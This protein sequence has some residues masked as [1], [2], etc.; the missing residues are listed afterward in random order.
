LTAA[1]R[2]SPWRQALGDT[3]LLQESTLES[4]YRLDRPVGQGGMAFVYA[5]TD[6]QLGGPV[7]IKVL[8]PR[9]AS[10]PAAV[11]RFLREAR[12][13][14]SARHEHVVEVRDFGTRADGSA[15]V[16][17]EL[18][19][20]ETFAA[21]LR[22]EGPMPWSRVRHIGAQ[23][24]DA[25]AAVH[26]AGIVHRDVTPANIFRVRRDGDPDFLALVDFG[27]AKLPD[28]DDAGAPRLTTE[29]DVFGTPAFMAPEQTAH[30]KDADARSDVYSTGV[31]LYCL[32]TARLP[33]DGKTAIAIAQQQLERE[34]TPVRKHAP[35]VHP[36][37]EAVILRAL[38]RD[39]AQRHASIIALGEAIRATPTDT[40]PAAALPKRAWLGNPELA[41]VLAGVLVCAILWIAFG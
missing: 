31:V 2:A 12:A 27:L 13:L 24:C 14:A 39:P 9:F 15:F 28:G 29:A 22:R 4:R 34:P 10:K 8:R 18:L 26:A 36:A 38:A 41:L 25:L 37:V 1:L 33:F 19:E 17:M 7:A 20:G 5:G 6:L 30:A 21:T 32:L 40:A 23:L 16:V 3:T 11:E 35:A